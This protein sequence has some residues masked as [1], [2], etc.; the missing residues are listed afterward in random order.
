MFTLIMIGLIV[1]IMELY[2]AMY[3]QIQLKTVG[4][5]DYDYYDD[6]YD[7]YDYGESNDTTTDDNATD[8][9]ATDDYASEDYASEDYASE[10]YASE[11]YA[12][13]DYASRIEDNAS[14]YSSFDYSSYSS[15]SGRSLKDSLT[16]MILNSIDPVDRTFNFME[17]NDKA[18]KNKAVCEISS[19]P[20][21]AKFIRYMSPTVRGLEEYKYAVDAGEAL[22]DCALLFAECHNNL[23]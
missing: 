4:D 7:D 21:I 1:L 11:D 15:Y 20:W 13:E 5:Y 19:T 9:Y 17:I 6:Y 18:C 22:Q 12:S 8:D 14:D 3:N 23:F 2:Q 16:N 10:D